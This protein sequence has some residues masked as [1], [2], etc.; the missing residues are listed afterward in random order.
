[1]DA[2]LA[3]ALQFLRQI[4]YE[5]EVSQREADDFYVLNFRKPENQEANVIIRGTAEQVLDEM[6]TKLAQSSVMPEQMRDLQSQL[7]EQLRLQTEGLRDE[8][9]EP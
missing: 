7:R 6:G 4:G 5:I 9:K 3:E 1:M 8:P 2:S